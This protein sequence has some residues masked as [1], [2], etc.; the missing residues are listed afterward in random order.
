MTNA[1][2]DKISDKDLSAVTALLEQGV[3]QGVYP[4]A[5]LLVGQG[6]DLLYEKSVG[7]RSLDSDAGL[8]Q[9]DTV[10]DIASITTVLVTTT[11]VARFIER[12]R[13]NLEDRVARYLQ[14]ISVNGKGTITIGQLLSH[15]GGFPQWHPYFEELIRA[16]AGARVGI[17]TSRGAADYVYN[18]I[19]RSSLKYKIGTKQVY[20]DV[21][22]MLLGH[23]LEVLSGLSLE[24]LAQQE[25]FSPLG[26][27][28]TA[29]INLGLIKRHGIQPVIDMIA[30]TEECSWRKRVLC[31]EVHDDNAWA[32]GGIAGHSGVFSTASD[33]YRFAREML[34]AFYGESQYLSRE[35]VTKLWQPAEGGPSTGWRYGWDSPSAENGMTE[36]GLSTGAVGISGFTGCSLW[37]E[38][39][40]GLTIILM[41]NRIHPSRSN[42]KI[43]G[44]RTELYQKVMS[45]LRR[46][47]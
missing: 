39:S 19:V 38:P 22:F 46:E 47:G 20:S 32:M 30:P 21:G 41:T 6:G 18:S 13:L 7:R 42:K 9:R 12:Q 29:Y 37:I 5:V 33:L 36:A 27:K 44:F 43:R 31:G 15:R 25:I 28:S 2:Q 11:L 26:L 16:N 23:L 45:E 34:A 40:E 17:M 3:E 10:F 35:V 14:G 4:G 24:K 1:A 8:M